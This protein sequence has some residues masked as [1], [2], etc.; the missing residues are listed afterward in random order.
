MP[1]EMSACWDR[2]LSVRDCSGTFWVFCIL[3]RGNIQ[4]EEAY[5]QEGDQWMPGCRHGAFG[6]SQYTKQIAK[7]CGVSAGQISTPRRGDGKNL[8]ILGTEFHAEGHFISHTHKT[9][10]TSD[11]RP[12]GSRL[13]LFCTWLAMHSESSLLWSG[14]RT[15]EP[16]STQTKSRAQMCAI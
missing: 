4:Y 16:S 5:Q 10:P 9:T 7:Y 3:T 11:A 15:C 1:V 8:Q 12:L 13:A 14:N 2:I 6:L